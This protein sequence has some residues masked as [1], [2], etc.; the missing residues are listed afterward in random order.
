MILDR[1]LNEINPDTVIPK[2]AARESFTVKG[3]GRR[4]GERALVYRI[5]N[6]NDPARPHEKGVTAT[7][8]EK[9][10]IELIQTGSLTRA[11]FNDHLAACA[12]EGAY[13]FT[14]IGGLFIFLGEA[15]YAE[16]GTTYRRT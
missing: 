7:D 8:L 14:T 1:I 11:W 6:H 15:E 5:P 10:H 9:A 3:E 2:P 4:R 13:N 12:D 16:R